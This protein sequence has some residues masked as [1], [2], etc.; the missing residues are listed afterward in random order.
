MEREKEKE[1]EKKRENSCQCYSRRSLRPVGHARATGRRRTW[2]EEKKMG[3]RSSSV[4][5]VRMAG[6]TERIRARV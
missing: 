2:C 3:Q 5:V 6:K 1:R 4:S